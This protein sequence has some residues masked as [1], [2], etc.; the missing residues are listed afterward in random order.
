MHIG[1]QFSQHSRFFTTNDGVKLHYRVSGEGEPLIL[2]PGWTGDSSVFHRNYPVLDQHFT[3]YSLDYRC[4]GLSEAP[5]YG[6]R[7]SRLAMDL[8][9]LID[10]LHIS[11]FSAIGH[12]MG[13][14]VLWCYITLFGQDKIKKL[15]FEDEPSCL[16]AN[17]AWTDE[18]D[19][20]WTGGAQKVNNFWELINALEDSWQKAFELFPSYFPPHKQC[21][22]FPEYP[23][24]PAADPA[25]VNLM[26]LDNHKHA[27]IL[28]DHM[29]N[30]WRDII[31][32]IK[33]PVLLIAGEASHC[34]TPKSCAWFQSQLPQS[35]L[36]FIPAEEYGVHEMHLYSSERFNQAA[37]EFLTRS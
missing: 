15:I 18:E 5:S 29:T 24:Y 27:R 25:P 4:H 31:P 30:D 2:L 11:K 21:P 12:S 23:G 13:N 6:L 34:S 17:P 33:V 7:I 9:E 20:M 28:Q 19:E 10:H 37:V 36:V 35:E 26:F 32:Q 22:P 3:V 16:S 1:E 14:T 8:K